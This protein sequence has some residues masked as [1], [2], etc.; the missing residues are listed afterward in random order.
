MAEQQA[1]GPGGGARARPTWL[2]VASAVIA[3]AAGGAYLWKWQ[4]GLRGT[5]LLGFT[6]L[7]VAVPLALS[8]ILMFFY[9]NKPVRK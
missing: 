7:W 4:Q 3:V 8:L 1:G 5:D 2:L 9:F 6:A